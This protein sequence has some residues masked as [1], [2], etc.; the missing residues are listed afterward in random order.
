[1]RSAEFQ[2]SQPDGHE[3]HSPVNCDECQSALQSESRQSLSFLLLDQLTIPAIGCDE[4]LEEFR[5]V[6]GLTTE[7][8][9]ELLD[10]RPAGGI[11]CPSCRLAPYNSAHPM[12]PIQNGATVVLA[13]PEHQS[14]IVQR[15]HTGLQT[16]T[17]LTTGFGTHT[18][19][20]L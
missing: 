8:A 15:Y 9:A 17:Y 12:I 6:C 20:S 2:H 3:G 5:S 19:S 7:D 13:C 10:H 16:Q 14:E 11:S 18:N 1:M 4:H